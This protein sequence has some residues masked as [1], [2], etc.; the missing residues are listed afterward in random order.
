MD[1]KN[2]IFKNSI[3]TCSVY[4]T[5]LNAMLFKRTS[6]CQISEKKKN[7]TSWIFLLITLNINTLKN[8]IKYDFYKKFILN[9]NYWSFFFRVYNNIPRTKKNA[10]SWH[11]KRIYVMK[12]I[13]PIYQI[14]K[15][16]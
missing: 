2:N 15:Q 3:R 5:F 6:C 9:L 4:Q 12:K 16:A 1:Y 8:M 10:E 14:N 13:N 7:F 11:S